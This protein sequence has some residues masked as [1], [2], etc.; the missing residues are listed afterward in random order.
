MAA[1]LAI[2]KIQLE[3]LNSGRYDAMALRALM[4]VSCAKSSASWWSRTILRIKE[5]TGRS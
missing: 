3:N 2:L 1:L 4:K 5:N